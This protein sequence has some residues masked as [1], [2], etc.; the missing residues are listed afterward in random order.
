[1]DEIK[2]ERLVTKVFGKV[3]I[4]DRLNFKVVEINDKYTLCEY[5]EYP[6]I[7]GKVDYKQLG[8][9]IT[10]DPHNHFEIDDVFEG[11]VLYKEINKTLRILPTIN[12]AEQKR[13][14]TKQQQL[15]DILNGTKR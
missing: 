14:K 7:K 15:E 12:L 2:Y 13:N 8:R 1:M 10:V 11:K 9:G 6:E 5:V 4:D 3:K